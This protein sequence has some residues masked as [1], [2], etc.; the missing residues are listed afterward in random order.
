MVVFYPEYI[1][2]QIC[3]MMFSYGLAWKADYLIGVHLHL[4][5]H[6]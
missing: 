5:L 6:Y 4:Q 1:E 2:L 3:N